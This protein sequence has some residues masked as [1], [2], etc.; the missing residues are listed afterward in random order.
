[1]V[2][3][4]IV[5]GGGGGG[6]GQNVGGIQERGGGGGAGG[7]LTGFNTITSVGP[8]TGSVGTGGIGGKYEG[9][10]VQATSG[11]NSQ[12]FSYTAIGGGRGSGQAENIGTSGCYIPLSGG[13]GGGAWVVPNDPDAGCSADGTT[14]GGTGGQ[15][16]AGGANYTGGVNSGGGGGGGAG[17]AGADAVNSA[18]GN[19]GDGL[20]SSIS[21]TPTYYAGGGGGG[22]TSA[23]GGLGGGGDS[24]LVDN[25]N[26]TPNT[27]G[28][29]GAGNEDT[30][31]TGSVGIVIVRYRWRQL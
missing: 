6:A 5:A 13:S 20:Q 7:F 1:L 17:A 8:Y 22:G 4:L 15:G 23:T 3:Y 27:G 16:N 14:Y 19:G 26:A 2:E 11:G 18:G 30:G 28:G 10:S 25:P 24:S 31:G 21:G 9:P 29:G 12:L